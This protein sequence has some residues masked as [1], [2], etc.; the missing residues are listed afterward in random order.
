[1]VGD[2][3][4]YTPTPEDLHLREAYGDWVHTNPG[5][6]LEGGI[7][8]D[9]VWQAWWRELA[10]M[11]SRRYAA[12]SGRVGRRFVRTLGAELKRVRDRLW[13]SER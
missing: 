9:S 2:D 12:P 11:P 3:P 10:F 8:E 4:G 13:N 5:T 1:M 6:H 7:R